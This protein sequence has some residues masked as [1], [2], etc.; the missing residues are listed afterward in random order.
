MRFPSPWQM[1]RIGEAFSDLRNDGLIQQAQSSAQQWEQYANNLQGILAQQR[2]EYRLLMEHAHELKTLYMSAMHHIRDDYGI[3]LPPVPL[4][5]VT[6]LGLRVS[7]VSF[8]ESGYDITPKEKRRYNN[9]FPKSTTRCINCE[10]G[11]H[12]LP[13]GR[14]VDYDVIMH[15]RK[16]YQQEDGKLQDL[17]LSS[18]IEPEWENSWYSHGIGWNEAGNWTEGT[19]MVII[20]IQQEL[21]AQGMFEI[22]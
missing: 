14:R 15:W 11:L 1:A 9:T 16:L 4:G 6:S 17:Q 5:F 18:Y 21:V 8:F 22:C 13:P 20:G 10:F 2:E 7:Y 12:H 19:Y 3:E